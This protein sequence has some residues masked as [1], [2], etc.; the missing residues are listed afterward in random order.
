MKKILLFLLFCFITNPLYAVVDI[1]EDEYIYVSEVVTATGS[2]LIIPDDINWTQRF[3]L[4]ELKELRIQLESTR[5][6]LNE[7]LNSRELS[8]VDRALSYNANTVNFFWIIITIA[9]TGF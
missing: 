5:R 4:T 2:E 9:V 3:I 6:E 1:E 7:E 8:S